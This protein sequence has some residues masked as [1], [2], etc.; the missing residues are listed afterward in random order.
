MASIL[1][2]G[3]EVGVPLSTCIAPLLLALQEAC[4]NVHISVAEAN[5]FG[6]IIRIGH[7]CIFSARHCSNPAHSCILV[8]IGTT[9]I[10][11]KDQETTPDYIQ[12]VVALVEKQLNLHALV[13]LFEALPFPTTL[14]VGMEKK[15]IQIMYGDFTPDSTTATI[16]GGSLIDCG[17]PLITDR[18]PNLTLM[19]QLL[20]IIEQ[21]PTETVYVRIVATQNGFIGLQDH[22]GEKFISLSNNQGV[23][24]KLILKSISLFEMENFLK[25]PTNDL[26]VIHTTGTP[27][28]GVVGHLEVSFQNSA[29]IK[30]GE[31]RHSIPNGQWTFL[32]NILKMF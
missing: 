23:A 27:F 30:V 8:S 16:Q 1:S 12:R 18:R 31:E 21:A 22:Q 4:P 14:Y 17:I 6:M 11:Y 28:S 7:I 10:P 26:A 13:K 20:K 19:T 9:F 29:I 25:N 3:F 15:K 2:P 32:Q 5:E 24:T